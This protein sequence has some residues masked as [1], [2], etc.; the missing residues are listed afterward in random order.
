M[1]ASPALWKYVLMPG[2]I[3]GWAFALSGVIFPYEGVIKTIWLVIL[4]IW[5]VIHPL[6]IFIS[7]NIG[8]SKN[9]SF[10]RTAIKT[11]LFG[12]T[13]WLPLKMGVIEK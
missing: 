5:A 13:W 2:S 12:F 1:A 4:L 3:I 9:I 7:W 8:K 11:I 6:E 10:A